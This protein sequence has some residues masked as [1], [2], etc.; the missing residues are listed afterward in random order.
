[1]HTNIYI[2]AQ[3]YTSS[4]TSVKFHRDNKERDSQEN[5]SEGL[6]EHQGWVTPCLS[7]DL[8]FHNWWGNYVTGHC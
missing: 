6:R 8:I 3:T 7:E 1:M 4:F 2:L 5:S